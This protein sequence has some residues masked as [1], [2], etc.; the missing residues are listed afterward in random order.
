MLAILKDAPGNSAWE[1]VRNEKLLPTV[2]P[3]Q[4]LDDLT[5]LFPDAATQAQWAEDV[6]KRRL[7][8]L[9][10]ETENGA[11]RIQQ[12]VGQ[13][14]RLTTLDRETEVAN[15]VSTYESEFPLIEK[16]YL[17]DSVLKDLVNA[18]KELQVRFKDA[19]FEL[20]DMA[21]V[22]SVGARVARSTKVE[23]LRNFSRVGGI[24][25]GR[26]PERRI[27]TLHVN[28]IRWTRQSGRV[29]LVVEAET[30]EPVRLGTFEPEIVN[31]ALAYAV[32]GR[33]TAVTVLHAELIDRDQVMIHPALRDTGTGARLG[34]ADE[35]IFEVLDPDSSAQ[36]SE[37]RRSL[38]GL[39]AE[40]KIYAKALATI[41]AGK[42]TMS[43]VGVQRLRAAIRDRASVADLGAA[44]SFD[45]GLLSLAAKC[46]AADDSEDGFAACVLRGATDK[47][48]AAGLKRA[49][50]P[51][52][53]FVS[54][55]YEQP[56]NLDPDLSF[57]RPPHPDDGV[58]PLEFT[59]QMI[60]NDKE[61]VTFPQFQ[62][63]AKRSS[64]AAVLKGIQER[65]ESGILQ[66]LRSFTLLGRFFQAALNGALGDHFPV[67]KLTALAE[68]TLS[69][70][71]ACPT[72]RWIHR[73]SILN[74]SE[75]AAIGSQ[76]GHLPDPSR[77]EEKAPAAASAALLSA[78]GAEFLPADRIQTACLVNDIALDGACRAAKVS[79]AL[80]ACFLGSDVRF[81]YRFDHKYT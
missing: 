62:E 12:A 50:A 21:E 6:R 70:S 15:L 58:W 43:D 65:G 31:R 78:P 2:L 51:R 71:A 26:P 69:S 1:A 35:W 32:D 16:T 67:D 79:S 30:G 40:S 74:E 64:T 45:R 73:K 49:S 44:A 19:G 5:K 11:E 20:P 39:Y 23:A 56:Y 37:L 38:E 18:R 9:S 59:V 60:V 77:F 8:A 13:M 10:A 72:P 57:L 29:T 17:R 53:Q 61:H 24:L 68:A 66:D 81:R 27:P 54:Q 80:E 75:E 28:D 25:I 63:T 55:I 22:E 76:L 41:K 4:V 52:T 14:P 7:A 46:I 48:W 42:T 36:S 34:R 33:V 3:A 47:K